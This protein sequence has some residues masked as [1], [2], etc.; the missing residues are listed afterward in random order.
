MLSVA[1]F[2]KAPSLSHVRLLSGSPPGYERVREGGFSKLRGPSL[3][4]QDPS[5]FPRY[6]IAA[7]PDDSELS[8]FVHL[9]AILAIERATDAMGGSVLQEGG[10]EKLSDTALAFCN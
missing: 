3:A 10:C 4:V 9:E 6:D 7:R 8:R 1:I 5:T 2:I